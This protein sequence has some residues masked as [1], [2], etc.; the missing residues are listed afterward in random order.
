MQVE[1]RQFSPETVGSLRE[2]VVNLARIVGFV[3]S[4]HQPQPGNAIRWNA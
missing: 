3:A 4:K 1:L 2:T